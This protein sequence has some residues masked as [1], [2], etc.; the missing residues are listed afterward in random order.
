MM[1]GRGDSI[2]INIDLIQDYTY[3]LFMASNAKE[4]RELV[5]NGADVNFINKLGYSPIAVASNTEVATALLEA[6]ADI[7]LQNDKGETPLFFVNDI[8]MIRFL[9]SKG[10][11]LNHKDVNGETILFRNNR[12]LDVVKLVNLGCNPFIKNKNG[13]FHYESMSMEDRKS[14][15]AFIK[16]FKENMTQKNENKLEPTH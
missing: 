15:S 13:A 3:D 6:G 7:H 10:A 1:R 4:V 14:Y 8:M 12:L 9:V 5:K 16:A 2:M 11:K